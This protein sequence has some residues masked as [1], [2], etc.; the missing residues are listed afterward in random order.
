M[1]VIDLHCHT[2]ASDGTATPT[3]LVRTGI[4]HAVG[5]IGVTDH[6]TVAGVGEAQAAAS[7]SDLIVVAGIELS[8]RS[9]ARPVH[10]L[11][12]F[13]DSTSGE[14][15]QSLKEVRERR[16]DRARQMVERLRELGYEITFDD[17]L[18]QAHGD[19]VA[20]PHVARALVARGY[21]RAVR[22]AFTDELI[23]DGGRAYVSRDE[24]STHDALELVKRA[25]GVPVLAHPGVSHHEGRE[26]PLPVELIDDLARA[27]LR[28][29]EVDHP[30]HG[31]FMR[32]RLRLIASELDLIETGGSDWHGL[33]EHS[34]GTCTTSEDSF[35]RLE[36]LATAGG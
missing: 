26:E 22:D 15:L 25:G 18:A 29:L 35:R 27:G 2:T 24:L 3:E 11:G 10:L 36:A 9:D 14:L 4:E 17:V 21:I 13:I 19:V 23:G 6:D 1:R 31:T 5:V 16:R 33:P 28:G 20:R 34:L 30:D 7:G 8:T 12:Y 32:D